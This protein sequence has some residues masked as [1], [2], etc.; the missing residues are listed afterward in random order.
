MNETQG[1]ASVPGATAEELAVAGLDLLQRGL[2]AK[3]ASLA[4]RAA[5]LDAA[6]PAVWQLRANVA[7]AAG[8]LVAA[9]RAAEQW[10][11]LAPGSADAAALA[12]VLR[13]EPS[14]PGYEG[15]TAAPFLL[16][17]DFL[18]AERHEAVVDY[19]LESVVDLA[20]ASVVKIDG[21]RVKD[22]E[23]RSARVGYEPRLRDWFLPLVEPNFAECFRRF[24]I[25]PFQPMRLELQLTAS[26]HGDFYRRHRDYDPA[27]PNGVE[28][29]RISFVYYFRP[30]GGSF[31][32]GH[33]R[34][35]DWRPSDGQPMPQ[36]FT[37][38]LPLDNRL[39][40]FPSHALH[41]VMPVRALSGRVEDGRFTLN[42]WANVVPPGPPA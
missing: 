14:P 40:M 29:R 35:Y 26:F 27:M 39:I 11:A 18:P 4:E 2:V 28:T 22:G 15:V 13:G 10:L 32:E 19:F 30:E 21:K 37:T 9:R 42:G 25:Q 34:L 36:R 31:E 41:E 16:L 33:L 6:D 12:A 24:A 3:A 7:R 5:A 38:I 1:Q 20:D 8:D 17:D 23:T